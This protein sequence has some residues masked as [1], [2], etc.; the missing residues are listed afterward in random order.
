MTPRH[1]RKR[2]DPPDVLAFPV[3][4]GPPD[5]Q[6]SPPPARE[7]TFRARHRLTHAREFDAVYDA[8]ARKSRGPLL[9]FTR[10]N[11]LSHHRLGLAV[12]SRLGG[13]VLRNR[14]KRLIRE[15]FRLE[16][17]DL[18][19]ITDPATPTAPPA[20]FDIIVSVRG[21]TP[22]P[23]AAYRKLLRDLVEEAAGEWR[24]RARRTEPPPP[25]PVP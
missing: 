9:V 18:A 12:S 10:P 23:L 25:E 3:P 24:K 1:P 7:F 19:R 14:L 15:A 17:H 11:N 20:G 8:K 6:P 21:G 13:A 22:L 2:S 16:Q 5:I 4:P